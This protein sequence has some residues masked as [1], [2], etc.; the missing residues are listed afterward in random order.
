MILGTSISDARIVD[1]PKIM[2][3]R[4]NLSFL[5]SERHAPFKIRRAYWIYDVPGG[6]IRGSHAFKKQEELL[7][8]LSGSFDVVLN[9][10]RAEK[11]FAMNRS[12]YA[13]Y[14]PSMMWRTV[15]NFSTNSLCLAL[16]STVYEEG[17]YIRD[18]GEYAGEKI[19]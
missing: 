1:L 11:V 3:D 6:E 19:E 16:S 15:V 8:A 17:D 12:Y 4:G 14:I 18:F 5:E 2:D 9:D 13:L 7:V 10:G